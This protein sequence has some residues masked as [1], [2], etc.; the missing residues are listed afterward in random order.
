MNYHIRMSV[1]VFQVYSSTVHAF[2]FNLEACVYTV[3]PSHFHRYSAMTRSGVATRWG[4]AR[5]STRSGS[6]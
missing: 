3:A 1:Y 5:P 2:G 6:V 4:T